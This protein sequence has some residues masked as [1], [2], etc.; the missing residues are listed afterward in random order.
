MAHGIG[1]ALLC[2]INNLK[3]KTMHVKNIMRVAMFAIVMAITLPA[4]SNTMAATDSTLPNSTESTKEVR[5]QQMVNRLEEIKS[6][7][8]SALTKEQK[9][10][11]R[12]EVKAIRKEAK[13]DQIRGIYLS[14]GAV[15][16]IILLLIL[17]L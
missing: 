10:E 15:I 6:M 11:L 2:I 9:K 13:R 14:I 3:I 1:I 12:N 5:A 17:I 4:R 8:K 16:I 7:D